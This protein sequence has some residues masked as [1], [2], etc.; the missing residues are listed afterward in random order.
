MSLPHSL[1]TNVFWDEV[2]FLPAF[3]PMNVFEFPVLSC[4]VASEKPKIV[5]FEPDV[6]PRGFVFAP[7]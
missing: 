6:I 3:L 2:T 5:L 1:P 7:D 4:T